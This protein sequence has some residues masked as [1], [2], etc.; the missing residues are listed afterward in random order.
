MTA[1]AEQKRIERRGEACQR[2]AIKFDRDAPEGQEP[3]DANL[4]AVL[5]RCARPARPEEY[6]AIRRLVG[7]WRAAKADARRSRVLRLAAEL[8]DFS[9]YPPEHSSTDG[10]C[11]VCQEDTEAGKDMFAMGNDRAGDGGLYGV[12]LHRGCLAEVKAARVAAGR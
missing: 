4:K 10:P 3:T 12:Y 6:P 9:A 2:Y 5:D 8:A 1:T 7:E 11:F